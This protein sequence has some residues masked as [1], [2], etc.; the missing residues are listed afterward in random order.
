[1]DRQ[2]GRKLFAYTNISL[3]QLQIVR[4][5]KFYQKST[6]YSLF[7]PGIQEQLWIDTKETN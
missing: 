2:T 1:M 4:L 5:N 7:D 3:K 6:D